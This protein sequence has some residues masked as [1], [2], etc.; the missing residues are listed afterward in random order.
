MERA[1]VLQYSARSAGHSPASAEGPHLVPLMLLLMLPSL[2]PGAGGHC[3][4]NRSQRNQ[5]L[6]SALK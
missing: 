4:A 2:G 5:L 3:Q 1:V 6:G